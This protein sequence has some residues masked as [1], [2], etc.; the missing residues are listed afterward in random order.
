MPVFYA[1]TLNYLH[2]VISIFLPV[3]GTEPIFWTTPELR[4]HDYRRG[5]GRKD[6]LKNKND[7]QETDEA[8]DSIRIESAAIKRGCLILLRPPLFSFMKEF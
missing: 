1:V 4:K 8:F 2:I 6:C 3:T 5:K 7:L